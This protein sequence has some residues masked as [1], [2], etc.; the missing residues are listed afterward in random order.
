[1]FPDKHQVGYT[2]TLHPYT[3][4]TKTEKQQQCVL[5]CELVRS[6]EESMSGNGS[7]GSTQGGLWKDFWWLGKSQY[8]SG[9]CEMGSPQPGVISLAP[10]RGDMRSPLIHT[11]GYTS[12]P[13][14]GS[15]LPQPLLHLKAQA[16]LAGH[17]VSVSTV[18]APSLLQFTGLPSPYPLAL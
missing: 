16:T 11:C 17:S 6:Q 13:I 15:R 7:L 3:G 12:K 10:G 8:F 4:S 9:T 2:N 18:L 14:L 5:Y 1:M